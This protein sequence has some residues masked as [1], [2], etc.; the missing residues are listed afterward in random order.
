LIIYLYIHLFFFYR[1]VERLADVVRGIRAAKE[2]LAERT[3]ASAA[4]HDGL[5]NVE[6]LR[7]R[8]AAAANSPSA[9]A[10]A[11][12]PGLE[13]ELAGAQANVTTL[14][15]TYDKIA[16]S[17]IAEIDRYRLDL[18]NDFRSILLDAVHIYSRTASKLAQGWEAAIP[19]LTA[20]ITQE[21]AQPLAVI[22]TALS[23]AEAESAAEESAL[24][25]AVGGEAEEGATEESAS[26]STEATEVKTDGNAS[27]FSSVF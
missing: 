12:K 14:R 3:K 23:A 1:L 10:N 26:A 11:E 7:A 6:N 18:R 24:A 13:A 21:G 15:S 4:L 9:K 5:S 20:A 16:A 22:P 2:L 8:V 19:I 17:A 25:L 27:T